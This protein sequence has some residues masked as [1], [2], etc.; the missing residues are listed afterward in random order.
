MT[1]SVLS[2]VAA[3]TPGDRANAHK[4]EFT[5]LRARF[6]LGRA[7]GSRSFHTGCGACPHERLAGAVRTLSRRPRLL[8]RSGGAGQAFDRCALLLAS[9]GGSTSAQTPRALALSPR[10][11]G[12]HTAAR[13]R[14]RPATPPREPLVGTHRVAGF[15]AQRAARRPGGGL[16]MAAA[17]GY[18]AL[19]HGASEM[20][21]Q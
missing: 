14:L 4:L 19:S 9:A 2:G 20:S 10:T 6:G 8:H 15:T 21:D 13:S 3:G 5:S 7:R 1:A 11:L 18:D 17:M 12:R 16:A